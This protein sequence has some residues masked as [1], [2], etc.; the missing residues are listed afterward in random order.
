MNVMDSLL[1]L[2]VI[3]QS[4][5]SP[6]PATIGRKSLPLTFSDIVWL[7]FA[8]PVHT[9]FFYELP[10][11]KTQFTETIV[12]DLKQSLSITLKHFFPFVG[13]LTV[14]PTSTR[15]PEICYVEG[16]S[17]AVTFAECNL[18]FND[19]TG[20]HPR[21]CE[22]F[23]HLIPLL[24]R[25]I[26][27]SDY[28]TIPVFA[29]QVTLFPNCGIS[30]GMTNHHSL[31]DA[32][33]TFCFLKA[34]TSVAQSNGS[35][36]NFL[37]NGTLPIYDRLVNYPK[38]D[39]IY[40]KKAKVEAFNEEYKLPR[41]CGPTDKVRA[42][43]ILSRTVINGLKKLV[44]TQIPTLAYL[45]SFTIACSYIW[46]CVASLHND[47]IV[48]FGF[49]IDCRS[50]MDPPIPAAYFGNFLGRCINVARTTILT[51]KDGFLAAAELIG[52]NLNK[53]L[54]DKDGLVKGLV[55]MENMFADG[56]PTRMMGVA[57]SPKHKLYD[58]DFG[59]GKPKKHEWV[60]IDYNVGSISIS[61]SRESN[62]DLEIGLCLSAAE[63]D[64]FVSN[65]NSG[66]KS[67]I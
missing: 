22:K 6:P 65:F 17:I 5:V 18:D 58:L 12:P 50:R 63:M 35:D 36:E 56:W 30:I 24:G 54:T 29:V 3:E 42:T 25:S 15:K 27:V 48:L 16:D 62:E 14:F 55:P 44:S 20:N 43:F 1:S 66:L 41:L 60:S 28:I 26:K 32:S 39:E 8:D 57:G 64:L 34:W 45:S 47:E 59:F 38:L 61:T 13:K 10:I 31:G 49:A 19:L 46:N 7:T 33:T 4:Q 37:A 11:T 67:Y 9:L 52:E 53:I 23:Y 21:D 51:G 40:L 2:T